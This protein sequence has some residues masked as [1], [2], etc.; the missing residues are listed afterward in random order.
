M[1]VNNIETSYSY[2]LLHQT[3]RRGSITESIN[4][5]IGEYNLHYSNDMDITV[6]EG[7]NTQLVALGYML[8]IRNGDLTDTEI[9]K[10]LSVSDD[11]DRELDYINGRYVLIINK[12]GDV[13]VYTDASALLPINYAE[14]QKVIASHD[15]LI[16]EILKQNNIEVK[17]LKEELKG[18]FDFTRY[19]R[20]FKFNPSLKLN[21]NTWEFERYYPHNELVPK[22][23]EFV[24]KELEIYFNEMIKWLKNLNKEIILTLTGGYDSRVSMALTNS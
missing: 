20:I 19:E 12:E 9:L 2:V 1:F 17:L 7:N 5:T 14:N 8:D 15:I 11:I 21:L 23:I 3:L 16:E 24:V 10:S 22:S 13:T 4:L 6:F 18:S